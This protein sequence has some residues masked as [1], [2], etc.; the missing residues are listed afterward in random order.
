MGSGGEEGK[1]Y[2]A[3]P[4][5]CLPR[6]ST[7]DKHDAFFCRFLCKALAQPTEEDIPNLTRH[8]LWVF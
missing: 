7:F 1:L 6:C 4:S 2:P 8:Y 5:A 3:P